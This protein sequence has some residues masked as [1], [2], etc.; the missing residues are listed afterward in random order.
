LAKS[1]DIE[2]ELRERI[3]SH[4]LLPGVKLKE[5]AFAEEFGVSR[6]RIRQAFVNLE[7]RGLVERVHNYGTRVAIPSATEVFGIYD[8]FEVLEGLC[9]RLAVL[10]SPN[11]RWDDLHELFGPELEKTV[12][13]GDCE[14]LFAAIMTYRRRTQAA[15]ANPTLT[16]FLESIYD[17]T[18]MI[19]RRTLIL[20]GRAELSFREHVAI[21]AAMREGDA[22]KAEILKRANMRTAREFLER[23]QTFIL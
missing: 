6:A 21:I 7:Q 15:A 18:Q 17:K 20:P 19:I 3:V 1:D 2:N 4:A 16:N 11:D 5:Q 14:T 23:Y 10:N 22:E 9:V 12:A 8:V 13:I